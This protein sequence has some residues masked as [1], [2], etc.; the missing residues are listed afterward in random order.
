[1]L[2]HLSFS[3]LGPTCILTPKTP[4]RYYQDE[5]GLPDRVCFSPS[6]DKCILGIEGTINSSIQDI[7]F[8]LISNIKIQTN[9]ITSDIDYQLA[10]NKTIFPDQN[11][12]II[13]SKDFSTYP[14]IIKEHFIRK[15]NKVIDQY[16]E[17][18]FSSNYSFDRELYP[19]KNIS[20]DQKILLNLSVYTTSENLHKPENLV[21][22]E[23][24]EEH[25]SLTPIV[26]KRI[27]FLS[28][29]ALFD[30]EIKLIYTPFSFF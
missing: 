7:Y 2:Y 21:D 6:I 8:N 15:H 19:L 22:F 16:Q 14:D 27:G 26:V 24:S 30:H 3:N 13:N 10:T 28:T 1:M 11:I 18:V 25:W 20:K 4:D 29:F 23:E 9:I 17:F 5:K 12:D